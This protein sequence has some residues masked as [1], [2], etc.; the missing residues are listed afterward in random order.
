MEQEKENDSFVKGMD[1]L[2]SYA[3]HIFKSDLRAQ[4]H[5][6]LLEK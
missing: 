1:D 6:E 3:D 4:R 5:K 2:N